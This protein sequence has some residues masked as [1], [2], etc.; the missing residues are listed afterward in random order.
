MGCELWVFF[1]FEGLDKRIC[2]GFCRVG[3]GDF[4]DSALSYELWAVGREPT[5][6]NR[7]VGHPAPGG[8]E[9]TTARTKAKCGGPSTATAKYAASGRD[10]EV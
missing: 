10:D 9:Q 4:F 8:R 7:D 1:G 2:W 3:W 6:Q 5:S